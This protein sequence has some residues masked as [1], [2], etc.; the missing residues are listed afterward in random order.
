MSKRKFREKEKVVTKKHVARRERERQQSVLVRNIAIGVVLVI[1]LLIGYGY[2]DQTV[3]QEQRSVAIVNGEKISVGQFQARVRLER[4]SLINQYIQYAQL[5]QSFGMDVSAQV[6]PIE[7][8][9]SNPMAVGQNVL[10]T[11]IYELIY[12]QEGQKEGITISPDRIEEELQG[13]LGYYPNGTPTAAPETTAAVVEVSTLS[14]EQLALVTITPTATEA[15]T[16][17]PAPTATQAADVDPT[18]EPAPTVIPIPTLT[19]T[20]YT[21]EGYQQAYNETLPLYT[22]YGLSEADFRFLFEARLYYLELYDIVTADVSSEG[23][24]IWAR[25][26]LLEEALVANL[27]QEKLLAG[28]DFGALAQELSKDPSVATNNGD[29]GWFSTGVMI[30]AFEEAAF[31]LVEV[32]DISEITQT[33][34]GFH[35]IQLLG[36]EM[37]PLEATAFQNKKDVV[38]QEWI[39]TMREASD[40]E[41]FDIWQDYVPTEPDLEQTI[42][43]LFG[44]Q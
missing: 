41:T 30:P 39:A 27:V 5:A 21:F 17:T 10:E 16:S 4:D 18:E 29:L 23:E 36:R 9:L 7:A 19:P 32:G 31:A 40:V 24:F 37:R 6:Q 3:L 1:V 38:F 25:H 11:M 8:Q 20:P 22:D 26:I 44:Q 12:R 15:P 35:I 42:T 2:L 28:E 14:P 34:F 33:D 43:E 13:F